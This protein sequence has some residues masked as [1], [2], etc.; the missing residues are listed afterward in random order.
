MIHNYFDPVL[1]REANQGSQLETVDSKKLLLKL[2]PNEVLPMSVDAAYEKLTSGPTPLIRTETVPGQVWFLSLKGITNAEKP[3]SNEQLVADFM[4]GIADAIYNLLGEAEK[5]KFFWSWMGRFCTV[6]LKTDMNIKRKPDILGCDP[7]ILGMVLKSDIPKLPFL[8][9]EYILEYK[10][11][12]TTRT[13]FLNKLAWIS[14]INCS[15][16]FNLKTTGNLP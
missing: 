1:I 13:D 2:F 5:P 9:V 8:W 10:P 15:V 16:C 7:F 3:K 14:S 4:Q 6:L 12:E 11:E